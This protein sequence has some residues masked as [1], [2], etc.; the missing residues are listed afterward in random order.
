MQSEKSFMYLPNS[1][2]SPLQSIRDA[3]IKPAYKNV[4][5]LHKPLKYTKTCVSSM[6]HQMP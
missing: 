2:T 5:T 1:W 6:W 4:P 3:K